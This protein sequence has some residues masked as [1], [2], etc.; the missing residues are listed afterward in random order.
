MEEGTSLVHTTHHEQHKGL[1]KLANHL[2]VPPLINAGSNGDVF[3]WAAHFDHIQ[4]CLAA[5][6]M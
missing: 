2:G 6:V 4:T 1:Q 3:A 5:A